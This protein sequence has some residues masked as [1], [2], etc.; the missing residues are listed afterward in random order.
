M[1]VSCPTCLARFDIPE[2]LLGENGRT[3]RCKRCQ[4]TWMQRIYRLPPLSGDIPL[5]M[6]APGGGDEEPEAKPA[7]TGQPSSEEDLLAQFEEQAERDAGAMHSVG[8]VTAKAGAAEAGLADAG[9]EEEP[10]PAMFSSRTAEAMTDGES[11]KKG[12][13]GVLIFLLLLIVILGGAGAAGYFLRAQIVAQWPMLADYYA[14][15]GLPVDTLGAGLKFRN[16]VSERVMEN[17]IEMLVVR[18]AVEN[19]S[20]T[21]RD[22]PTI[23]LALYDANNN[24]VQE[25]LIPPTDE[26]LEPGADSGFRIQIEAPP[27]IARRFEVTFS[28]E[29]HPGRPAGEGASSP[30]AETPADQPAAGDMKA[31]PKAEMKSEPVKTEPAKAPETKAPETKAPETKAPETKAPEKK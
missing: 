5:E 8:E 28:A 24:V 7:D 25:R 17:N 11:G 6:G 23:R 3:V 14:M 21:P 26:R 27:A 19:V 20:E 2:K 12:G 18:G 13:K 9:M 29:P 15:A 22:V 4:N 31:E 10:I 30:K 1:I 16:V